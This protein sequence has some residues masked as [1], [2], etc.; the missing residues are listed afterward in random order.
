M[1]DYITTRAGVI[2]PATAFEEVVSKLPELREIATIDRDY[3][4]AF[5]GATLQNDD[6]TLI[7]RGRGKGLKIY[8]ELERDAHAYA[9]LQKRKLAVVAR[10]LVIQ[11]ASDDEQDKKAADFVSETLAAIQ[12]DRICVDLLDATNKGF[13][14]GEVMWAVRPSGVLGVDAVVPRDLI[15]RNQRRFTFGKTR[16]EKSGEHPLRLLTRENML[17]GVELPDR[18]F[19]VH[20]FGAKDGSPFGL[21]LGNRLFW[22]VFFKRQGIGFWLTFCDKFGAPTA[23]GKYP[24]GANAGEQ[25]KLL[26]A[27]RA[28]AN[29]VGI[30]VPDGTDIE[31]LEASRS[32]SIDTYE[33]LARYMDEQISVCVTGE[34]MSTS[35]QG[36]GL[37]SG[38]A[39]VHNE[40]RTEVAKADAD[41]LA[42]TLST[43]VAWIVDYNLPGARYP[44][45]L[46]NFEE[47][48]DLNARAERDERIA[49]LGFEPDDD[50]ILKVYGPG[51]RRKA[52][53]T[54]P[55]V[56]PPLFA[57]GANPQLDANRA[58]Q[59]AMAGAAAAFSEKYAS[60]VGARIEEIVAAL[61]ESGD[62]VTFRERLPELL[63]AAPSKEMVDA[64]AR[65][66]FAAN[67]NGR[68]DRTRP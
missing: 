42:D 2:V 1:S 13:S 57:E 19:I 31:L 36:A 44:K 6:D 41:L 52:P 4:K 35:A 45:V 68:T 37:G 16:D 61:E 30:I 62:L 8:D 38:Q 60:L 66:G 9:M 5:F 22:P 63:K 28:I 46:R 15:A 11:P 23:I 39:N 59:E 58:S 26:Q 47:Q 27:L 25:S 34:T 18:K 3:T 53:G 67:L 29:D 10:N 65:A 12:F 56:T 14:V 49:G 50:Y 7:S 17:D 21:G 54:F 20:R 55:P 40:V 43:L 33:R 48:E 24:R 32:G 64:L 51:W